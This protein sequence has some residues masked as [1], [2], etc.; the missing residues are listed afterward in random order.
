MSNN[1][2]RR[3]AEIRI[4]KKVYGYVMLLHYE[5]PTDTEPIHKTTFVQITAYEAIQTAAALG[6]TII[7]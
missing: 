7:T 2:D 6:I 5:L 3:D 1:V 4:E